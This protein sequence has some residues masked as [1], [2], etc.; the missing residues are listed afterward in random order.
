MNVTSLGELFPPRGHQETDKHDAES[1]RDIPRS[2][3]GNRPANARNVVGQ[4]PGETE[5]HQTEHNRLE[6]DGVLITLLVGGAGGDGIARLL[7]HAGQSIWG[8]WGH[9]Y[10]PESAW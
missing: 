1:D 8:L 5:Q 6:P 2:V 4:N 7:S 3:G 10:P 9:N